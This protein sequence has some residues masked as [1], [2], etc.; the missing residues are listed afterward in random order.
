MVKKL[1]NKLSRLL[2]TCFVINNRELYTF[3]RGSDPIL[4]HK[5]KYVKLHSKEKLNLEDGCATLSMLTV[6][7]ICMAINSLD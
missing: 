3:I 2:T 1:L 7:S 5:T 4:R 6:K